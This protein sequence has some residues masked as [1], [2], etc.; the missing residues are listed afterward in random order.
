MCLCSETPEKSGERGRPAEG[1][2]VDAER[3]EG[4]DEAEAGAEVEA[5]VVARTTTTLATREEEMVVLP[6]EVVE[7]GAGAVG[8]EDGVRRT[9]VGGGVGAAEGEAAAVDLAGGEVRMST[10]VGGGVEE[11]G[12]EGEGVEGEVSSLCRPCCEV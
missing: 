5:P 4:K 1:G 8:G 6:L 11:E 2:K 12:T 7:G 10:P 3:G 9:A